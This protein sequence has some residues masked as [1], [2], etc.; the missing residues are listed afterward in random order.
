[1]KLLYVKI[2]QD[3]QMNTIRGLVLLNLQAAAL[4]TE[5]QWIK[6]HWSN[7]VSVIDVQSKHSDV[8]REQ[9]FISNLFR[10]STFN[11]STEG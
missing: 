8:G 11:R 10:S 5:F 7:D 9:H 6:H 2:L 3:D 4:N 1:M